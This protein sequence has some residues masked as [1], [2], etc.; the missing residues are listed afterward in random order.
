MIA[1]RYD[2]VGAAPGASM[3]RAI[4]GTIAVA[5]LAGCNVLSH[6][7]EAAARR[8]AEFAVVAFVQNDANG[9]FALLADDMKKATS[10]EAYRRALSQM[11][12]ALHPLSVTATEF[13]PIPGQ[14]GMSIFL[15][16]ENASESF[17]YRLA[18]QG[19]S[20]TGYRV[21]GLFRGSGP[22]PPSPMRKKLAVR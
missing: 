12:P 16:G 3:T 15:R 6:D 8:A 11:H 21:A 10:P 17:F 7:P 2:G 22:Y 4:A 13:E 20:D 1:T 19:T 9:S 14:K 5:A 18:M